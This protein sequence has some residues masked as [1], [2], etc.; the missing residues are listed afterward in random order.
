[1]KIWK[2]VLKNQNIIN[3]SWKKYKRFKVQVT[4]SD[5]YYSFS[6]NNNN[7]N[8]N[9]DSSSDNNNDDSSSSNNNNNNNNNN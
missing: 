1:M 3:G 9:D 5:R 6:Y 8:N 7:N 4:E 2:A